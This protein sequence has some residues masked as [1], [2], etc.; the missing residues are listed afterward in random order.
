MAHGAWRNIDVRAAATSTHRPCDDAQHA[1]SECTDRDQA[2]EGELFGLGLA[3]LVDQWPYQQHHRADRDAA[4][5]RDL[6]Q[7]CERR[8]VHGSLC[9]LQGHRR[10]RPRALICRKLPPVQ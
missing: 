5:P 2:E 6:A 8:E 4:H 9:S 7:R 1:D 10:P 3:R